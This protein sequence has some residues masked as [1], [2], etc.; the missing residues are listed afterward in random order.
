MLL[1]VCA[2][3]YKRPAGLSALLE[4]LGRQT[5]TAM[6]RPALH[7]V[8][9]DNEGSAQ[10]RRI[11]AEFEGRSGMPLTYVHERARGISFARNACLDHIPP[12][13]EFF[14]FIDDDEVPDADWLERLL[15]AQAATDADAV[16]GAADAVFEKGTPQWLASGNFFGKPRRD[17]TGNSP[18]FEPLQELTVASTNNVLVRAASV[19]AARLRF[20]PRLALTGGE[21]T[22]FFGGL[23]AAGNRIVYAPRARVVERVPPERATIGYLMRV[24][25][26]IG[27]SPLSVP[28]EKKRAKKRRLRRCARLLWADS[29]LRKIISAT[30]Y[31]TGSLLSGKL[32]MDRT[33][34]ASL[35]MAHGLGQCARALG[36]R[37]YHYR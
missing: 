6:P 37:Y 24:E 29:G 11:C 28:V 20:D 26:R 16:Q 22:H 25:F 14:A 2:C 34:V 30:G 10:A 1:A 36:L 35:R 13:C 19:A 18:S 4:G 23:K 7:I 15:E 27:N 3:T 8:I 21:D 33:A 31:F 12:E 32:T 17:W 9:A 5:F